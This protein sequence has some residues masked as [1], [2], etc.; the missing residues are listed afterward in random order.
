ME[1]VL[2]EE[3]QTFEWRNKTYRAS[4]TARLEVETGPSGEEV[5]VTYAGIESVFPPCN[6]NVE[7][8][9]PG[10][11]VSSIGTA[12]VLGNF[13]MLDNVLKKVAAHVPAFTP[14]VQRGE[15]NENRYC[16]AQRFFQERSLE[17]FSSLSE[18]RPVVLYN[19]SKSILKM[20]ARLGERSYPIVLK[21]V[22]NPRPRDEV[23]F[24]LYAASIRDVMMDIGW[25]GEQRLYVPQDKDDVFAFGSYSGEC[26]RL[27]RHFLTFELSPHAY[28]ASGKTFTEVSY[29]ETGIEYSVIVE[30]GSV[31]YARHGQYPKVGPYYRKTPD[32]VREEFVDSKHKVWSMYGILSSVPLDFVTSAMSP[33]D[34]VITKSATIMDARALTA[35]TCEEARQQA[36]DAMGGNLDVRARAMVQYPCIRR[37]LSA[38]KKARFYVFPYSRFVLDTG[39]KEMFRETEH[40]SFHAYGVR[41]EKTDDPAKAD[42]VMAH[43]QVGRIRLHGQSLR[44]VWR[45]K[46]WL[47]M[48]LV[49]SPSVLTYQASR[50]HRGDHLLYPSRYGKDE[51]IVVDSLGQ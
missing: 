14:P 34:V 46:G 1:M 26:H 16:I 12:L 35:T 31:V 4:P 11:L 45:S 8:I 44:L 28:V 10:Q 23:A 21:S 18:D 40:G 13:P 47:K 39:Q 36:F 27:F 50:Y 48:K 7:Y 20:M 37:D 2:P 25:Q 43:S 30:K 49:P 33:L 17:Q 6:R 24:S 3:Y 5:A 19:P 51:V 29:E 42:L 22:A 38:Y 41:Y 32:Q 15:F 9:Q